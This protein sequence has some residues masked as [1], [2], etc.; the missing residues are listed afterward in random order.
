MRNTSFKTWA[1]VSVTPIDRRAAAAVFH[2]Q[3][4]GD[5]AQTEAEPVHC[6]LGRGRMNGMTLGVRVG[7]SGSRAEGF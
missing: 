3:T 1:T 7:E 4:A 2:E 6:D 5:D